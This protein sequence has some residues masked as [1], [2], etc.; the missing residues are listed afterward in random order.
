MIKYH[1]NNIFHNY[2]TNIVSQVLEGKYPKARQSLYENE[3]IQDFMLDAIKVKI[4]PK[5]STSKRFYNLG[6]LGHIKK[7]ATDIMKSSKDI[8]THVL[9][10]VKWQKFCDIYLDEEL[11]KERKDLGGVR[12]RQDQN[13]TEETFDFSIDEI[14]SRFSSFLNPDPN[15]LKSP[16]GETNKKPDQEGGE[17]N[18]KE[19]VEPR[20]PV[21][22]HE[23]NPEVDPNYTLNKYWKVDL[24]NSYDPDDLL[25][26]LI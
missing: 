10:S 6:Y 2:V 25:A 26:E 15:P 13:P 17:D 1:W 5:N 12:V 11:E 16:V 23:T 24:N 20:P 19:L 18:G 3:F 21:P 8:Q 14:R 9:E 4:Q 7:I 22:Q